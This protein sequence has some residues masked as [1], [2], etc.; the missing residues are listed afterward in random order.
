[1]AVGSFSK[2]SAAGPLH[3]PKPRTLKMTLRIWPR[4][5][6][7]PADAPQ[8]TSIDGKPRCMA[9]QPRCIDFRKR[10]RWP[11]TASNEGTP[12]EEIGIAASNA[13][14]PADE[15]GW[16]LL[17]P[18]GDFNHSNGLQKFTHQSA[19]RMASNFNSLLAKAGRALRGVPGVPIF[20]GHPD[21]PSFSGKTGHSDTRAHAWIEGVQARAN[22]LFIKP[23]WSE[24]GE[25][26]LANAHY[27]FLSPR[28]A[29]RH[30]RGRDFEPVKLISVGLTNQPN[31]PVPAIANEEQSQKSTQTQ[32]IIMNELI[33]KLFA[34]L[35]FANEKIE[36]FLNKGEGAPTEDEILGKVDAALAASNEKTTLETQLAEA[37]TARQNVESERD[38]AKTDLTAAN[39]AA[40]LHR[41]AHAKL[42]AGAAVSDGRI[43]PADEPGW[44]TRFANEDFQ[45]VSNE[46]QA[47]RKTVKTTQSKFTKGL[48]R[49]NSDQIATANEQMAKVKAEVD[50]RMN[51]NGEDY[52]TAFANV[53]RE[54]PQLFE[55]MQRSEALQDA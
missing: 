15:D 50:K 20:V 3:N 38:Q 16:L 22:G 43:T 31:I 6:A 55:E 42:L 28:W 29:M 11:V 12:Q 53:K 49:M 24:T 35:G 45:T 51:D 54:K 5:G 18:F 25:A 26:I 13:F 23:K 32:S 34:K 52:M 10:L 17:S 33:K 2:T 27:R 30:I 9:V 4:K 47:A 14:S 44:L 21:D 36:A 39:T 48:G 41:T 8:P 40:T 46:L 7:S 37:K 19:D 1:M